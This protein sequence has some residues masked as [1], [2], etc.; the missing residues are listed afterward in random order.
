MLEIK[1]PRC[2]KKALW[3]GNSSRPFCSERCRQLDLG[4]WADEEYR[5]AGERALQQE[6]ESSIF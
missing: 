6:D 4:C 5:L 1:C 3:H 2:G